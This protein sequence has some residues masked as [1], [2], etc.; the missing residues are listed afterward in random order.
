MHDTH[1]GSHAPSHVNQ[2]PMVTD[3]K[4]FHH[5]KL[6]SIINLNDLP[7]DGSVSKMNYL[8][9]P[10]EGEDNLKRCYTTDF[11]KYF[12]KMGEPYMFK[13]Y[14]HKVDMKNDP[15]LNSLGKEVKNK[16]HEEMTKIWAKKAALK[17]NHREDMWYMILEA[18]GVK[19]ARFGLYQD[20]IVFEE[21]RDRDLDIPRGIWSLKGCYF[22][23]LEAAKNFIQMARDEEGV[24]FD[25][26]QEI[27][28]YWKNGPVS[29]NDIETFP[30][31]EGFLA[32]EEGEEE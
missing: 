2:L 7:G 20:K 26:P 5:I 13:G 24:H 18:G 6:L 22:D 25:W 28:V 3:P 14:N 23:D 8:M 16:Y 17:H 12:G 19:K 21:V 1:L 15:F 30:G 4:N 11:Q 29:K 9:V 32:T 10:E 27:P 31:F